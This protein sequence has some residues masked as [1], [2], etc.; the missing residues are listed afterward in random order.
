M[1]KFSPH[2][3]AV[4]MDYDAFISYTGKDEK[5]AKKLNDDLVVQGLK[6]F[7]APGRI[8]IGVAWEATLQDAL[9]KSRNVILLWS[10]NAALS[11]WVKAEA[12]GFRTLIY[13][14]EARGEANNR[15]LLQVCLSGKFELLSAWQAIDLSKDPRHKFSDGAEKVDAGLW[16]DLIGKLVAAMLL[17]LKASRLLQLVLA[18]TK[19]EME[20]VDFDH[21]PVNARQSL[22][23][24]LG[25]LGIA[26]AELLARYGERRGEWRPF[27]GETN[28]LA[29]L[30][31][32]RSG[33]LEYGGSAFLWQPVGDKFWTEKIGNANFNKLVQVLTA[34][35]CVIVIDALS[36]YCREVSLRFARLTECIKN[37]NAAIMVLPPIGYASRVVLRETLNLM[38]PDYY[39]LYF[40]LRYGLPETQLAH[41]NLLTPDD[42]EMRRL[43][44]KAVNQAS[45]NH[46]ATSTAAT[47]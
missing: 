27:Q 28:I 17:D 30:G 43:L 36:L 11:D 9:L 39:T 14:D 29:M 10:E 34:N 13:S 35:P 20:A 15:K 26:R 3:V 41:C 23:D 22:N 18:A 32:L 24:L 42:F 1:V 25:T 47:R 8:D 6:V 5:W 44:V 16:D 46:W 2:V 19:A 7:F 21:V 37:T 40:N 12:S 38:I 4:K 33:I 45:S 31:E